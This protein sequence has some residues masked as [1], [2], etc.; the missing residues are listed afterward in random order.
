MTWFSNS[1]TTNFLAVNFLITW[2]R[3]EYEKYKKHFTI[4][5]NNCSI[6]FHGGANGT[7]KKAAAS[8]PY[9]TATIGE[10]DDEHIATTA[11]VKGAYNDSI[12]A[13]NKLDSDKQD[14]LYNSSTNAPISATVMGADDFL[15]IA[16]DVVRQSVNS[17]GFVSDLTS[18]KNA[19]FD[20]QLAT[21]AG[22]VEGMNMAVSLVQY[23]INEAKQDKLN[24]FIDGEDVYMDSYV[25]Q[26]LN[27]EVAMDQLAS[28]TAIKD[29]IDVVDTKIDN[30]RVKIYTT[31]GND[32][33][34]AT[35]QVEL[36]AVQ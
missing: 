25:V 3:K 10:H 33:A 30:K 21:V 22:V 31:W 9:Q 12:R 24:T 18:L 36:D 15:P 17:G 20:A 35:T 29:A 4:N 2:G 26:D 19:G 32:T 1:P 6:T 7:V 28:A 16:D 23:S 8:G 11:Y 14:T 27:D 13:V 34:A 5:R